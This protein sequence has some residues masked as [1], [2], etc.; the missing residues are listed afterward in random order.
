MGFGTT[1]VG[2]FSSPPRPLF[3]LPLCKRLW[4]PREGVT[5]KSPCL[6]HTEAN[7]VP[8]AF[9]K[10]KSLTA[11]STGKETGGRDQSCLPD[12]ELG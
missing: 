7:T 5:A 9:E 12:L 6:M 10:R 1:V 8:R 2:S 3:D 11:R 4:V